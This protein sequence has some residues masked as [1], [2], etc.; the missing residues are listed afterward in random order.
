MIENGYLQYLTADLII[1]EDGNPMDGGGQWSDYIPACIEGSANV[2]YKSDSG[3][4][5]EKLTYTV[6]IRRVEV[7]DRVRLFDKQKNFIGEFSVK[8]KQVSP[9]VNQIRLSV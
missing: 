6:Y 3:M 4:R 5:Y 7:S 2:V 9:I 8:G 1:D